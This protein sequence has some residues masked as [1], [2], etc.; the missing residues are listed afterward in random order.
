MFYISCEYLFILADKHLHKYVIF[1][2]HMILWTNSNYFS[3]QH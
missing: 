3:K 1:I 2:P